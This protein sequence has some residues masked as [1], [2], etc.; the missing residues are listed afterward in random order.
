MELDARKQAVLRAVVELHI[1]SGEPVGSKAVTECLGSAI[2]SATIRN[3]MA[4]LSSLGLLG[5]PHTS[6][7]RVPTAAAFRL[8]IDSLM[9]RKD[10]DA[11][12][13][14]EIDD[15]LRRYAGNP[16]ELMN[17]AARA[18]AEETGYA[19]VLSAPKQHNVV[20]RRIETVW[21]SS[22]AVMLLLVTT[23]GV[24]KDRVCRFERTVVPE[25]LRRMVGLLSER[26]VGKALSEVDSAGVQRVLV[27][28]GENGLFYVPLLS[29]F[30]ELVQ[31]AVEAEVFCD[32][33][34]NLL[35]LPDY[36]P[37]MARSLLGFLAQREQLA[38]MMGACSDKLHVVLGEESRLPE[39]SCTSIIVTPYLVEGARGALGLIG[40]V[41]MNYAAAIPR[42]EYFAQS[43]GRL[44]QELME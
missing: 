24:L 10:L 44:L 15:R 27:Q 39:L 43:V 37:H 30:Y 38:H 9:Q 42:I 3:E 11:K 29:A 40:P 13:K 5:Q 22:R 4:E 8:Y 17:V 21:I 19:A 32:G 14:R 12:S 23:S 1:G 35:Q 7:G 34:L 25:E 2:S 28:F 20:L 26:Y 6:A 31:A 41:R 18:L 33:Q 16:E 36:A